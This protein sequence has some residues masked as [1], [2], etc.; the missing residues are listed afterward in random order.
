MWLS[1]VIG[2][3]LLLASCS[4]TKYLPANES[5]YTGAEIKLVSPELPAKKKKVLKKELSALTRPRPNSSILGLRPK[6]WFWNIGGT[7]KNKISIKRLIKKMGEPPVVLSDLNLEKNNAVLQSHLENQGFFR[8][9]VTGETR[10]KNRRAKAIYTVQPGAQYTINEVKFQ[11]DSSQLLRAINRTKRRTLLKVGKPFDLEVVKEERMRID[12]RLKQRGFY[13]FSPDHLLIDVDSTIGEQRVNLY[14]NLKPTTPPKARRVYRINE[15]AIYPRYSI[16]ATEADTSREFAQLHQGYYVVD[17]SRFYKP[18]LFQQAMQFNKGDVY[19]RAEHNATLNR[20]INLNIFKF[21]RNRFEE[22]GDTT[23]NAYYYLTPQPKKSLRI[24][25]GGNTKSNNLTGSQV[26]VGFTNRNTFR[27]G[28]I[29]TVSAS[30]GMEVQVS[31]QFRGYNTFRLGAEANLAIPRFIIPFV[32]INPRGGFVPRTHAQLGYDILNR[33]Q[34]YTLNSFRGAFGYNWKE[35]R[36]KEHTFYPV[37]VQYV[38]PVRISQLYLESMLQDPTLRNV[39]DTQFILGANYS[40]LLNQLGSRR[41]NNSFYYNGMVDLSGNIAGLVKRNIIKSGD[42]ARFFGAPFSQYLKLEN[43]FRYYRDLGSEN[44]WAN[45]L[46]VGVGF[47]YGN[48][49]ELP[50]IKQFFIG[51]NNSLRAFRSRSLGPGTYEPRD[52]GNKGFIPDQSGDIKLELNSELR[53]KI[54]KPVYGALFADAGNIWLYNE[55]PAKPGAAFS[56]SFLSELAV[57]GG[58]GVRVDISFIVVRLDMA[59]PLRKPWLPEKERWVIDQIDP[60]DSQWRKENIIFNL[61]IG[62][63]F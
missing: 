9:G 39:I 55:N 54:V 60:G 58:L 25:I 5:L 49:R 57:G 52:I 38:Q 34:L 24:E 23:L 37:S 15:V 3:C 4:N 47:P 35:T 61:A 7:P 21:V 51:G 56:K 28:E 62:Y 27:G 14:V 59:I 2:I 53:F 11:E 42:T 13:F 29:L 8:A 16:N 20:L 41:R 1:S 19:N 32:Q 44:V 22:A 17:S 31:G 26:T 63:P 18:K 36:D 6:L 48:S 30:G 43:D 45:R 46:I 33:Q 10:V 50:F 12:T 40:Y